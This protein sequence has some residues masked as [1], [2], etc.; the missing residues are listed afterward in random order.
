MQILG[1]LTWKEPT[2]H[3]EICEIWLGKARSP[4][5]PSL[6]NGVPFRALS[7]GLQGS[8]IYRIEG[9]STIIWPD[10]REQRRKQPWFISAELRKLI[11]YLVTC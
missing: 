7:P 10:Q 3:I 1:R 8:L 2:R 11:I 9:N 4:K 6:L 5:H